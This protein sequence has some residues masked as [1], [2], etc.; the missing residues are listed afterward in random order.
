M[1]NE[2]KVQ[3]SGGLVTTLLHFCLETQ[4]ELQVALTQFALIHFRSKSKKL[5]LIHFEQ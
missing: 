4:T 5:T 2:G 3:I 1:A